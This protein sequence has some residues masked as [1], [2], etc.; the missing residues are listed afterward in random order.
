MR[1]LYWPITNATMRRILLPALFI[2]QFSAICFSQEQPKQVAAARTSLP[3]K[4]DGILSDEAWK[5]ASVINGLVEMRPSFGKE[6]GI[7]NKSELYLLYDDN[8]VYFGGQLNELSRD[9][10]STQLVGRDEVGIN[11][12]IGI[13][14]DTYQD[15][16][17]GLGFYVS[18]LNEQFDVKYSIGGDGGEDISWNTVYHTATNITAK[19]WSFEMQIPYSALRFSKEKLQSCNFSLLNLSAE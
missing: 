13:V 15:K 8:A 9:S 14:F 17:N 1:F 10:I 7:H 18:P 16:I 5:T 11:D 4:L 12:F 6:E 19:G 3:I 2:L